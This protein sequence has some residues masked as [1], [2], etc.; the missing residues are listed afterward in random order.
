LEIIENTAIHLAPKELA[1]H[2]THND[3]LL[4]YFIGRQHLI[5]ELVSGDISKLKRDK[6]INSKE[7]SLLKFSTHFLN[8]IE[9]KSQEGYILTDAKIN[10]IVY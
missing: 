1:I 2:L 4:D 3:I 7:H 6:C 5:S 9:S 10:F 8:E